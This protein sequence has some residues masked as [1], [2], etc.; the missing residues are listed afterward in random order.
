MKKVFTDLN[1]YAKENP[2]IIEITYS[3]TGNPLYAEQKHS[4]YVLQFPPVR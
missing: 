4:K 1:N 3:E 2:N